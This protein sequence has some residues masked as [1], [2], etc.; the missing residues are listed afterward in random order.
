MQLAGFITFFRTIAIFLIVIYGLKF[1]FRYLFPFL[2]KKAI[3]KAQKR[4]KDD[5]NNSF[6]QQNKSYSKTQVGETTIDKKPQ[7]KQSSKLDDVG[8]YVDYEEVD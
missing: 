4:A 6:N 1:I 5:Q 7:Q 8:E 3:F 2:L